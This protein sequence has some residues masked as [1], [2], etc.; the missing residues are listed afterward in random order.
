MTSQALWHG[1]E[2]A[3]FYEFGPF[4]ID[5]GNRFLLRDGDIVPLSIKAFDVLLVLVR[6]RGDVVDKSDLIKQVWSDSFVEE[7]NLSHHVFMLRKQLGDQQHEHTY[8]ETIPRRGYR[9]VADVRETYDDE[10]GTVETAL[11][12]PLPRRAIVSLVAGATAIIAAALVV[13]R[14]SSRST[15]PQS[16]VS[17]IQSIAVL[18]FHSSDEYSGAGIADAITTRLSMQ[19]GLLVR[20]TR[21]VVEA[22]DGKSDIAAIGRRLGVDAVVEGRV[23]RVGER[24]R[25]TARLVRSRDAAVVWSL[26]FDEA[27]DAPFVLE[28]AIADRILRTAASGS[29]TGGGRLVGSTSDAEAYRQY[30]VGRYYLAKASRERVKALPYFQRAVDRDPRFALAYTAIAETWSSLG[31]WGTVKAEEWVTPAEQAAI[32]ALQLDGNLSEAQ[33]AL[34]SVRIYGYW[35]WKGAENGFRRAL[36]LNPGNSLAQR[37]LAHCLQLLGRF[38]EAIAA[39]K[40]AC[41][42]DPVSTVVRR[43]A[44]L[45]YYMARRYDD[46]I[47]EHETAL[48]MN[49]NFD[50]S[51]INIGNAYVQK[52]QT[53]KGIQ[54]LERA[55]AAGDLARWNSLAWL[56]YAYRRAG[57]TADAD[58]L[59]NDL[60]TRARTEY[61]Q[62]YLLAVASVEASGEQDRVFALLEESYRSRSIGIMNLKTEPAWDPIRTDPRFAS[63]LHRMA[64]ER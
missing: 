57:R 45:T 64:L 30:I 15:T 41:E 60:T 8:I 26:P 31:V 16:S 29:R 25:A 32:H 23:E 17:A 54:Y 27:G 2:T 47:R 7:G 1:G 58:R 43:E 53:T 51:L 9:F 36:Q 11:A 56:A 24:L 13:T 61:V 50:L 19:G 38:D 37:Q 28:D 3:R 35:D 48:A 4:R 6:S 44:A 62:P 63:L 39:R 55:A 18:P 20:S 42:L 40:R 22:M 49:P 52:R 5:V 46:A 14:L 21:T 33:S 12:T 10:P 34:A 59:R